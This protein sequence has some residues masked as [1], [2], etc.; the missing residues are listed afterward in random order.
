MDSTNE[1][2]P[3]REDILYLDIDL[4]LAWL[5]AEAWDVGEWTEDRL[6]RFLRAAYGSGYLDA[7]GET[8]RGRLCRDHGLRVPRRGNR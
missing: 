2:E 3:A 5:W 7:L 8:E 1:R 4:R 6:G